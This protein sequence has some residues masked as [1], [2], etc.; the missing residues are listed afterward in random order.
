MSVRGR[1]KIIT[2]SPRKKT[3]NVAKVTAHT[4]QVEES[5]DP[6][7]ST[8]RSDPTEA[9]CQSSF[10]SK[11]P[12]IEI[13]DAAEEPLELIP[14]MCSKLLKTDKDVK[15]YTGVPDTATWNLLWDYAKDK[16]QKMNYWHGFCKEEV[17][18]RK[19]RTGT[20]KSPL[21]KPG[22]KRK[23]HQRDELLM[24]LMRL[25]LGFQVK[26]LADRFEVP[27]ATVSSVFG[28]WVK[29]LASLLKDTITM[30]SSSCIKAN[31]PNSFRY[32]RYSNVRGILDCTEI[33]I[34]RPRNL[35]LQAA[36]WSDYKKTQHS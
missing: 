28:T 31:L 29:V 7:P 33:F 22:R 2:F 8:S 26:D 17:R 4:H 34:E 27:C 12:S 16:V 24:T 25:R 6:V 20:G 9:T 35:Q 19:I 11:I 32:S 30:P 21:K 36:T 15:Y 18:K 23:L 3:K 5:Q 14:I 13:P 1:R 10:V